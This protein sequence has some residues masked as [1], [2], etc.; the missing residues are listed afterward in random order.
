MNKRQKKK[1]EKQFLKWCDA[2]VSVI[3]SDHYVY[4]GHCTIKKEQENERFLERLLDC[5]Y[6]V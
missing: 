5:I 3:G 4:A 1:R 6:R 2:H